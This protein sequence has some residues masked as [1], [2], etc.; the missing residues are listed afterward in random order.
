MTV[1]TVQ[2]REPYA[3]CVAWFLSQ[4]GLTGMTANSIV[5]E[6]AVFSG[7]LRGGGEE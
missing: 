7:T 1:T 3:D 5:K 6:R 4:A 2:C